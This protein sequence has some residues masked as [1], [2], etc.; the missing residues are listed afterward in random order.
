M[1]TWKRWFIRD[2]WSSEK[3]FS[4]LRVD[5]VCMALRVLFVERKRCM[6]ITVNVPLTCG[7]IIRDP[8]SRAI[9]LRNGSVSRTARRS[10]STRTS[11]HPTRSTPPTTFVEKFR[12]SGVGCGPAKPP[13]ATARHTPHFASAPLESPRHKRSMSAYHGLGTHL[14]SPA[15]LVALDGMQNSGVDCAESVGLRNVS[16]SH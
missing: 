15:Q 5:S 16:G 7:T 6:R 14:I 9:S 13:A 2:F 4:T 10:S 12:P 3:H 8:I 1:S 11:C